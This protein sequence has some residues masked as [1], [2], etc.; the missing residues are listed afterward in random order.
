ML[1]VHG[2]QAYLWRDASSLVTAAQIP[3][4]KGLSGDLEVA[5][6]GLVQRST[7]HRLDM[8]GFGRDHSRD[9]SLIAVSVVRSGRISASWVNDAISS[10]DS[11]CTVPRT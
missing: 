6:S 1:V 8:F 11:V 2:W 9:C 7:G 5:E 10:P 3:A 4:D